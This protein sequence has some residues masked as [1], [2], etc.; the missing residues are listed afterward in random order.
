[1]PSAIPFAHHASL[2]RADGRDGS[3]RGTLCS[4]VVQSALADGNCC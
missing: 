3:P 1:M 2:G 4:L